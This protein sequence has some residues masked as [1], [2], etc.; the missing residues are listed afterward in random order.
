MYLLCDLFGK[1]GVEKF[2]KNCSHGYS[3]EKKMNRSDENYA[4]LLEGRTVMMNL[5]AMILI[6]MRRSELR[7]KKT[8]PAQGWNAADRCTNCVYTTP[9]PR[10]GCPI[11]F[12]GQAGH[13]SLLPG[14]LLFFSFFSRRR[15]I[16]I[17]INK[18]IYRKN[19]HK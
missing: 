1:I 4:E 14:W 13:H 9:A 15:F 8:H 19:R 10:D 16:L 12:F 2:F 3:S 5:K 7:S 6:V 18:N 17:Q 11:P